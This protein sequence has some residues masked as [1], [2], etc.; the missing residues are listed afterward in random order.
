MSVHFEIWKKVK[1]NFLRYIFW[2]KEIQRYEWEDKRNPCLDPKES[3]EDSSEDNSI[4][5]ETR[6]DYI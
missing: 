2:E 1:Y 4:F 5:K 3:K 6:G